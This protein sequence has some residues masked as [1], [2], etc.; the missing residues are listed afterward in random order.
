[1]TRRKI[2][3]K[4]KLKAIKNSQSLHPSSYKNT[5][6]HYIE[7]YVNVKRII[8]V[9]AR[10]DEHA[11]KRALIKEEARTLWNNMGYIFVDV[12]CNIVKENDHE[13]YKQNH[14]SLRAGGD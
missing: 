4:T 6:P 7:T 12:D 10:D 11:V 1:M 3:L 13:S 2:S 5:E 8:R 14:K 9:E